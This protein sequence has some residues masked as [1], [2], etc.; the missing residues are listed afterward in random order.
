M[1]SV[2]AAK[3]KLNTKSVLEKYNALKEIEGGKSA[4]SVAK[5]YGVAKN[6]VSHWIKNKAEIFK[7]VDENQLGKKRK[8]M[9]LSSFEDLDK[10][11]YK[12]F[13]NVRRNDIPIGA[14]VIKAKALEYAGKLNCDKFKASDG[15]LNNW[16]V[17]YNV[18]F[19]TI[20]GTFFNCLGETFS[21]HR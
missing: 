13:T 4:I 11:I 18:S 14:S 12:W 10:A 8:R 9:R 21:K 3:R 7:A 20:S 17:R 1:A 6:T 15:W 16:K 2:Q 19:K 5:K